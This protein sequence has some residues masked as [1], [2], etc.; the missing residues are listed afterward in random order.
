MATSWTTLSA[1]VLLIIF[2]IRVAG[3]VISRWAQA[4]MTVLDELQELGKDRRDE[5]KLKGT[6][7]ICG[8]R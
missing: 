1:S 5:K 4:Y 7:V 2:A 8:G 6:A 3:D